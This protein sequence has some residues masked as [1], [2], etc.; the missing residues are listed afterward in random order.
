MG[1]ELSHRRSIYHAKSSKRAS[2]LLAYFH[3]LFSEKLATL[4][5]GKVKVMYV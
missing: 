5:R 3:F 1:I 2:N 4:H